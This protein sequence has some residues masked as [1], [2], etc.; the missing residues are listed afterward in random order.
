MYRF[1]ALIDIVKRGFEVS[2][3][4]KD[5]HNIVKCIRTYELQGHEL[6]S[7]ELIELQRVGCV[8]I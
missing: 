8:L 2:V 6:S 7:I 5:Y 4:M 3:S 1:G